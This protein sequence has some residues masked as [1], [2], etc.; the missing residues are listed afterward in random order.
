M[1]YTPQDVNR[2]IQEQKI[3]ETRV[4]FVHWAT[5]D[6][7]E[8]FRE[9]SKRLISLFRRLN[10]PSVQQ[11][12]IPEK[13]SMAGLEKEIWKHLQALQGARSVFVLYYGG[14]GEKGGKGRWVA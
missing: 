14:H 11:Y 13:N 8:A 3:V 10:Y 5:G 1:A 2:L 12:A 6:H 9:D 7:V 4:L